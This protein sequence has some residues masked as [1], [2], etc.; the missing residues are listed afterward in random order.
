MTWRMDP[1]IRQVT[2]SCEPRAVSRSSPGG[3]VSDYIQHLRGLIGSDVLLQLPSVSVAVRD[4]DGRV[5]LA[6]HAEGDRWLLPG[7]GVEVG[8]TPADAAVREAWEETGLL[9]R[10]TRLVGVFGGPDYLVHYRN[11]DRASYVSS[12]FEAGIAG[13]QVRPDGTELRELRFVSETEAGA[14]TLAPWVP[15]VLAAVFAGTAG[16]FRPPTWTP[17]TRGD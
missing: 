3:F 15:E 13:G 16:A 12:V 2:C 14:L 7:G 4:A 6:R 11:G 10:L 9:V 17:G 1:S 5:L 8:E